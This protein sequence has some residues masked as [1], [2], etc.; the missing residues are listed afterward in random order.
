M[1]GFNDKFLTEMC[2]DPPAEASL[3]TDLGAKCGEHNA[4]ELGCAMDYG[5]KNSLK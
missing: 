5:R 2:V 3:Y 4:K 1:E